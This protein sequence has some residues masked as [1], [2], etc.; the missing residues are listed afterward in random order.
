MILSGKVFAAELKAE[1]KAKAEALH[2]KYGITPGLAV[3][4]V[5][6]DPASKV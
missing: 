3:I 1:A 6:E 2:A 5:G 4:I